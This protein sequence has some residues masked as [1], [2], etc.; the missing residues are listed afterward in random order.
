MH[1]VRKESGG[2]GRCLSLKEAWLLGTD[3]LT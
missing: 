3:H 1:V 2:A